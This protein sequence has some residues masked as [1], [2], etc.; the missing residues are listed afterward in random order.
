M[1]KPAQNHEGDPCSKCGKLRTGW[2]FIP[3][4]GICRNCH[5]VIANV[6]NRFRRTGEVPCDLCAAVAVRYEGDTCDGCLDKYDVR[7][8][9]ARAEKEADPYSV[10]LAVDNP[11]ANIFAEIQGKPRR[12]TRSHV[13]GAFGRCRYG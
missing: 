13:I 2:L 11:A 6:R 8:A 3:N 4:R 7:L 9:I 5:K 10:R 1:G 12:G